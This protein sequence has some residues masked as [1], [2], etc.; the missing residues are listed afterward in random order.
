MATQSSMDTFL[1]SSGSDGG[2]KTKQLVFS[3]VQ[4]DLFSSPPTS[5]LA[6][7]VSED[8]HM[9]RGIATL[10]KK[11]FGRVGILKAQGMIMNC[12]VQCNI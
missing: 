8:L 12:Y 3:E 10:F 2:K 1:S 9:G 7:C 11:K 5:S 4:G 6:H